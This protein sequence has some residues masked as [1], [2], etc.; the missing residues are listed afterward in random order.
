MDK[1][2]SDTIYSKENSF[3][4]A[5]SPNFILIPRQSDTSQG[6]QKKVRPN[7]NKIWIFIM[8]FF[9]ISITPNHILVNPSKLKYN[10]FNILGWLSNK[11]YK[12]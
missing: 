9:H 7:S 3:V 10:S 1:T 5:K 12:R 4:L 8:G 6:Q 11:I 2:I